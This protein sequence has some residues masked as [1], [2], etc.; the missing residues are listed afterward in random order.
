MRGCVSKVP[1]LLASNL[2]AHGRGRV[3]MRSPQRAM[4]RRLQPIFL[5]PLLATGLF[6]GSVATTPLSAQAATSANLAQYIAWMA[7]AKKMYPYRQSLDKM[8]RVMMCESTGNARASGGGGAW[9]GL[10]QYAP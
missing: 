10:Y 1:I 3:K 7:D 4:S 8:Y 5:V 2:L 9:L 6:I